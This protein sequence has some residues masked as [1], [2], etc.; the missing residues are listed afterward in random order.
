MKQQRWFRFVRR[1]RFPLSAVFDSFLW[2]VALYLAALARLSFEASAIDTSRY[3]LVALVAIATQLVAGVLFGLYRGRRPIASFGEVILLVASSLAAGSAAT[4]VVIVAGGPRL[5]PISAVLAAT[6]YQMLGALGVRYTARL[7]AGIKSRSSHFREHRTIVFG[8]GDAGEQIIW[9]LQRD[10]KT[11]LDPVALLDD[12]RTKKRLRLHGVPVVGN[13][14]DIVAT[15][16]RYSAD[17]ILL[18]IPSATQA[19]LNDLA[20]ASFEAGLAVKVL[21]RLASL[22]DDS[23]R[24][25]D[26]RDI[27]MADFLDRDEVNIDIESVR[28]YL[29][30]KR[31]LVTGAGGS[32]GSV[33][34]RTISG[35]DPARLIMLDHNENALQALQLSLDG[36]GLLTSPDLVLC[37]IRDEDAV[38]TVFE[39][40]HPEVVFHAA[41][42]KHV[43]FL[44]RFPSEG[45]KTNVEGSR[46]VLEAAA[47]AGVERYVNI[48]TDKAADPIN[49]LGRTKR[50]AELLTAA[51]NAT[52]HGRYLSVRFGNVLGSNGSVVPTFVEQ[53]RNGKPVTVTDPEVTRFFMTV[54]EAVLLVLQAGALGKGGDVLVLDMG[55]PVRIVDLATRLA[56]QITPDVVPQ[57]V[58]TGLRSGEKLHEQLV[59]T[60]DLPLERPHPRL[61]RYAVP[62]IDPK[63]KS[64]VTLEDQTTVDGVQQSDV[65]GRSASRSG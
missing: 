11:D 20:D 57:I 14:S 35:L 49:V 64:L 52:N 54:E 45:H 42:H 1:W 32:I 22:S 36:K 4:L 38:R 15:A 31:V 2:L 59:S 25:R 65:A 23:V 47:S 30:G 12:D 62:H 61:S 43:T 3:V 48:S 46:N 50:E 44:E 10:G 17:T 53:L 33:L 40:T 26:I 16:S 56:H 60:E 8:A 18:A 9:S 27:E 41:A 13:R 51:T 28:S 34:C 7:V 55:E 39:T 6:A 29:T 63:S 58:Y 21:P 24:A 5:L 19:E 37:D